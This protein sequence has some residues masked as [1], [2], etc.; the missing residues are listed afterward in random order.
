[1]STLGSDPRVEGV[2]AMVYTV[3]VGSYLY[4]G[5]YA[6]LDRVVFSLFTLAYTFLSARI[7][8]REEYGILMIVL[9]IGALLNL[10][11]QAGV[12]S[13]MVKYG[14]EEGADFGQVFSSAMV[15]RLLFATFFS[16]LILGLSRPVSNLL[17][18]QALLYPLRLMPLLVFGTT[19][20]N[21]ARQA[22]QARQD[23][24][25]MFL[26]DSV[27]LGILAILYGSLALAGRLQSASIVVII[28]AAASSGSVLTVGVA[29]I[30]KQNLKMVFS[31]RTMLRLLNFGKYSTVSELSTVLYSRIDT[32]MI[33]YFLTAVAAAAYNAAWVLSYGVNLLLSAISI[34]ALPVASRA[35]SKGSREGLKQVYETTTAVALAFTI[36]LSIALVVFAQ[37]LIRILY[38]GRYPEAVLVLRILAIWWVVKPFGTMAGNIFY[39]T[40]RPKVLASITLGSAVLNIAANSLLIPRYGIA[41]AA[42]AS[43]V[44][45]AVG[46]FTAYYFMRKWLGVSLKGILVGA[47]SMPAMWS[48]GSKP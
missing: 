36:P 46:I 37:P 10:A 6:L 2:A 9:S 43:I 26:V 15:L 27:S 32:V 25:Q 34:L 13:A 29:W 48:S 7:I 21:S 3:G 17:H 35:H 5:R 14:A 23:I 19:L 44:S 24:K 40:G 8:P 12:G 1:M 47:K 33:G 41:G 45:F 16:I 18:N 4:R 28:V 20:N 22:M 39:G 42:W 31:G 30:A 38:A 11:S